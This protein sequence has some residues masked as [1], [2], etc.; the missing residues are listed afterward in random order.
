M[1]A[2]PRP[3]DEAFVDAG[4]NT[5]ADAIHAAMRFL[6]VVRYRK[7]HVI[8]SLA[9][10]SL[11]GALYYF[12]AP[13]IYEASASLLVSQSGPD[14]WNTSMTPNGPSDTFIPTYEKLFSSA[15]VLEGAIR[16]LQ[17]LPPAARVDLAEAPSEKWVALLRKKL[18]ARGA[19][20]TNVI[21]LSYRSKTPEAAEAVVSS[22]VD[23]Y[24]KFID[25]T[26]KNTS[27][28]LV[29]LLDKKLAETASALDT[30]QKELLAITGEAGVVV[31]EGSDV[32][33]PAVQ[34]V[35]ELNKTLVDV[36][37]ERLQLDALLTA[38]RSAIRDG[39]DLRDHLMAVEPFV[40]RELIMSAL[41]L[42]PQFTEIAGKIEQQLLEDRARL[43]TIRAHYGPAHHEVQKLEQSIHNAE[44]YL[45][46]YQANINDRLA[47]V[48]DAQ[49]GPMLASMVEERL[50]KTWQHENELSHQYQT[51]EAEAIKLNGTMARLQIAEN[52]VQRL[53]NLHDT[54]LDRIS[55]IEIKKERAE[56]TVAVV[57]EPQALR[58]PVSPKLP[59]V[60]AFCLLGGL[61]AGAAIVYV[62][63]LLDDRFRSPEELKQQTGI[64]VLAMVRKLQ[65]PADCGL[66][67]LPVHVAPMSVES[68]A[69]RTLR[70]A[71]AFCGQEMQRVA[72]SSSEPSD[73]K[74]TV[75]ANLGVSY[76][77]A[78]KRTLL[79]D[80]DLRRPGL[81]KLFQLRGI[82]GLSD[83][84]RSQEP[85]ESLCA[86]RVRASGIERL[87]VLPC[88]PKPPDP[89]ELLASPRF[90]DLMAWA[91]THYDQI[92]IDCPPVM[93]ATD[94]A[95]VGRLVDGLLMVVQPDRNHR[96]L[97]LRAI[98]T[99]GM[100]QVNLVGIVAN[101]VGDEKEGGYY[102]Y[103]SGYGYGY[104]YGYGSGYGY[105]YEPDPD[106]EVGTERPDTDAQAVPA[107]GAR[108]PRRAA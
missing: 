43:Q 52:D 55:N 97:V 30:K 12:T 4:A 69:F 13:R 8:T 73:G 24:M 45:A 102:G 2:T 31:R 20:R 10:A 41:G 84:L 14:V 104:G 15:V 91:E 3:A 21:E 76:A 27:D 46:Q 49:L 70:T 88:G 33:H 34:R 26:H 65:A 71:L 39:G 35:I 44:Q 106:E 58:D 96:R 80:A 90:Q 94:A 42:N 78:G 59:L 107:Q 82:N 85:L 60:L 66:E 19:R 72:I 36:Q 53:R 37:K 16:R 7:A 22:V 77:Q 99:L 9:V 67:A 86:Q 5:G 63:D 29:E 25:E 40:G 75:L 93:A 6:R 62:L 64:P 57:S 54:L 101:R 74:T 83:I 48:R 98:E 79:I 23:S 105:G 108:V 87:D 89:A 32:V 50:A 103:G 28:V 47:R 92:L 1:S 51:A 81:S 95:I 61:G 100:M 17:A 68:E 18:S 11:L 38:I 56:V